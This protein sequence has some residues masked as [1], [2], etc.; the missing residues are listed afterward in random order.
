MLKA[1]DFIATPLIKG[2]FDLTASLIL[3]VVLSPIVVLAFLA[4]L[5][6]QLASR[7]ARG[8]F[9]YCETRI[10]AGQPFKFC[11]IRTCRQE[12]IEKMKKEQGFV[13]TVQLEAKKENLTWAGRC[14][15][16]IYLDEYPQFWNI[17]KGEMSL[18]GPRPANLVDYQRLLKQGIY[19]KKAIR[20]GLTGYFQSFKGYFPRTD[21][22]MDAEY[23]E[24]CRAHSAWQI[25]WFDLKIIGRT[26]LRVLEHRGI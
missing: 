25:L 13:H 16:K 17:L 21:I 26:I 1:D 5:I 20:A 9:F 12:A 7:S 10:S 8:H 19:T 18:V 6:E 24:F 11:K 3:A 22:E 23:I 14:L 2:L 4:I 15:K